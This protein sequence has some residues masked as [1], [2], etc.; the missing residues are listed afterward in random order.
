[1]YISIASCIWNRPQFKT[2][3]WNRQQAAAASRFV[4]TAESGIE[5]SDFD[6]RCGQNT[7][8]RQEDLFIDSFKNEEA[9]KCNYWG[10]DI[11][12]HYY[13]IINIIWL[14]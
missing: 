10:F 8:H 12:L 1:M 14:Y 3:A 4:L 2:N 6:S 7:F 5:I 11:C 9:L 13:I